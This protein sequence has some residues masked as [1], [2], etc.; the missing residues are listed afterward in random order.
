M[1]ERPTGSEL[2]ILLNIWPSLSPTWTKLYIYIYTYIYARAHTHTHTHIHTHTAIYTHTPTH[3]NTQTNTHTHTHTHAHA[4]TR[5]HTWTKLERA[6]IA[7]V[8]SWVD[9]P[10][11]H[12]QTCQKRPTKK[13][14]RGNET[15]WYCFDKPVTHSQKVSCPSPLTI[16]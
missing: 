12:S 7:A 4:H 14:Y 9:K 10:V 2:D 5:T 13:T 1:L 16:T 3:T 11:T 15:Y 8:R 6:R